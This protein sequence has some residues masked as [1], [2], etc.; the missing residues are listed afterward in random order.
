VEAM[1]EA[2]KQAQTIY[3]LLVATSEQRP[4]SFRTA[5]QMRT[6]TAAW[7]QNN[8]AFLELARAG[9]EV[10]LA[11]LQ[12]SFEWLR[13]E[14]H[15]AQNY[16]A[17]NTLAEGIQL[18]FSRVTKPLPA[19]LVEY[20][21]GE[22][23]GEMGSMAHMFFPVRL[24]ILSL[25][26]DQV[27][28]GI[29]TKL[30]QLHLRLAPS[31]SGK[32][33]PD[34]RKFRDEI[35]ELFRVD[36]EIQLDP[37]RGPWSQIVFDEIKGMEEIT[38]A[39]WETLLEHCRNLEQAA[40]GTKWKKRSRELITI[41]GEDQVFPAMLRWL[42]QGPTPG[43]PSE[44]R[45]PIEDSGYQKGVIWCLAQRDEGEVALAIADFGIACLRKIPLLGAVS[46]KV[47]FTCTQALG[48]MECSEAVAQL[49][50]MRGKIKY[51]VARRLIE[52]SLKQAAERTGL[53]VRELEDISVGHYG[54]DDHGESKIE[55]GDASAVVQLTD[56]GRI[57]VV[58][59]D[60]NGKSVKAAPSHIKKAF[61]KETRTVATLAKELEQSY[62]AQRSRLESSFLFPETMPVTHWRQYFIDHPLLGFLGRKLIWI[63][64][65][66]EGCERTGIWSAQGIIDCSGNPLAL[67]TAR[68]ARLWHPIASAAEEIQKWRQ[69]VFTAKI[70]QPFRQ[71]FREF[72]Q[73][74][75]EERQSKTYSNRFAGFVMRQH[76]FA[77]LC[78][79]RGWD[80]RLMG[81]HFD[82]ANV[83]TK[84]F[85]SWN[86]RAEL[87]VD[88]PSDRDPALLHSGLG[89]QSGSGINLFLNS[90]QVRFYREGREV[91]MD[92]VPAV[93]YSEVM[94]DVDLFTSVS[95]VGEDET[96]ADEGDRGTGFF[97]EDSNLQGLSSLIAL[98]REILTL[99]LPHTPI[100]DRCKLH[101]TWLE[102]RGQLGTYRIDLVWGGAALLADSAF[103]RLRI[104]QKVLNAV[105][106]D[107]SALSIDFDSRSETILR[108]AYVLADDW[109]IDSPDLIRQ[110]MPK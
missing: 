70:R 90:D 9:P 77:S 27:T 95:S 98:R 22:Y 91:A 24:L 83:P 106:L 92:D 17:C 94:R 49:T 108:K 26:R 45:S 72:Y 89:E 88:L 107:S 58:W 32:I 5:E 86:T 10:L 7:K 34:T 30:R 36:G 35:A 64:R 59:R 51:T 97:R 1:T 11:F 61:P 81:A 75:D 19:A 16:T 109:K 104:P 3:E 44:A 110:L 100:H 53:T 38:R 33:E 39:G 48:N 93:L 62:A 87:Y 29:R 66:D 43:Q 54:L 60:A 14:A 23:Y 42:A 73:V 4:M 102:V 65:N 50:R 99:A 6:E 63:F 57:A 74:T 101:N 85:D 41:L 2:E 56:D 31:A 28:D 103:R 76:Q 69:Y 55:I 15:L 67:N 40:P 96:W 80:Y 20:L 25:T 46:Q 79:T 47:G 78:R 68:T 82:G 105:S 52:K 21:F 13:A 18:A 37:G 8:P 12:H 71:A 84:K